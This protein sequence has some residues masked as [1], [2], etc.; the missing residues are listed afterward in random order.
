MYEE[1]QLDIYFKHLVVGRLDEFWFV[2]C[3]HVPVECS[4]SKSLKYLH[5][6]VMYAEFLV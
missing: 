2:P 6:F 5:C 1:K 3:N 4:A